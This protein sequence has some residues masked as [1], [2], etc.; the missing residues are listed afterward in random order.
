MA[1]EDPLEQ[2]N[3]GSLI[4]HHK[5]LFGPSAQC[6]ADSGIISCDVLEKQRALLPPS[7]LLPLQRFGSPSEEGTGQALR[8]V[9]KTPE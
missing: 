6:Q 3:L 5:I 4:C 8:A 1:G 7:L 2:K 9:I